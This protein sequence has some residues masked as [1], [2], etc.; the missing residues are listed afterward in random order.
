MEDNLQ[1]ALKRGKG[2]VLICVQTE[3]PH[4]KKD[5]LTDIGHHCGYDAVVDYSIKT[6]CYECCQPVE[7]VIQ[8][9]EIKDIKFMTVEEYVDMTS[10]KFLENYNKK[11]LRKI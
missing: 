6:D 1:E 5:F 8:N 3:C 11:W 4:C 7:R 10:N 2:M 9:E